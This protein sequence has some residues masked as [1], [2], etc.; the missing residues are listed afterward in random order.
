LRKRRIKEIAE[1]LN[2]SVK[3]LEKRMHTALKI[4]KERIEFI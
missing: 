4:L 3:A 2:I 1:Q